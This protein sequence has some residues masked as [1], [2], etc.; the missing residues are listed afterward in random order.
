MDPIPVI[1]CAT[2]ILLCVSLVREMNYNKRKT[3]TNNGGIL[4]ILCIFDSTL[5]FQVQSRMKLD[6]FVEL[7]LSVC[8]GNI[9]LQ[10][11]VWNPEMESG[12]CT[13]IT[14]FESLSRLEYPW[15]LLQSSSFYVVSPTGCFIR[16]EVKTWLMAAV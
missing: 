9:Y 8:C 10:F 6:K 14:P 4:F 12:A 5:V 2:H 3:F 15:T 13:L 1:Y 11:C 7:S 16:L